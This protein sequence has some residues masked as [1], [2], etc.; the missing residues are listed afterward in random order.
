MDFEIDR[1][2][3]LWKSE[4]MARAL[5]VQA[6]IIELSRN[7][8][9]QKGFVEILPVVISPITDPLVDYRVRGEIE[10]YGLKYQITKSMIFHKQISV[11][12]VPGIFSF[13]PNVRIEPVERQT[14]GKHLIEFVQLDIEARGVT[15]EEM[16]RLGEELFVV[17]LENI[18]GQ[19]KEDLDFF[20]RQLKI[21]RLPF[22]KITYSEA[23]KQ[24][25]QDY[26]SQLSQEIVEPAWVLDFPIENREFYDREYPDRPGFLVDMDLVYPEGFGEALSGGERE[27]EYHK[28]KRRI[29]KKGIDLK[30]YEIYLEVA[31]RGLSP[32]AGFGIGIERWTRYTCG[33]RNIEETRLFAKL[34]GL[35]SL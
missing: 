11:L 22:E 31:R 4:K 29:E 9:S 2:L 8:L 24:Y 35:L 34:P 26:E 15:R 12:T 10:C 23:V 30:V 5:R 6:K 1:Y 18:C 21:P 20:E 17:V 28:I 33:I 25:G 16:M 13:S 3:K 32:S 27:F 7:F 19:S 14:S